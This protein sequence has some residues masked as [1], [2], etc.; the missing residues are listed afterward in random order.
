LLFSQNV[1]P[2]T[3][4]ESV[5]E[6]FV[7]DQ[8]ALT[9]EIQ[10]LKTLDITEVDLQWV[11]VLS[12]GWATPLRGFMRE[13][14]YL[15]T[16]HFG[17]LFDQGITNQ[18]IPIVLPVEAGRK[19]ELENC[20]AIAL[21]YQGRVYAVLRAPEFYEHRKEERVCRQFGTS[22]PRHPYVKVLISIP[23]VF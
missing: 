7:R 4:S 10:T 15:Q 19:E 20:S 1:I 14:E 8:A 17:C 11:Q 23:D 9:A 13:R 3:V 12:E 5:L 2:P 18:A 22:N 21:R 6:L 16:L